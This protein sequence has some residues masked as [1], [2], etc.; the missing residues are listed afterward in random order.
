MAAN[1]LTMLYRLYALWMVFAAVLAMLMPPYL[2]LNI[3]ICLS[4]RSWDNSYGSAICVLLRHFLPGLFATSTY[5]LMLLLVLA[6]VDL[7]TRL[8][9]CK[10]FLAASICLRGPSIY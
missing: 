2:L 7:V 3:S 10:A 6:L 8:G 4:N 9:E 5:F 1:F